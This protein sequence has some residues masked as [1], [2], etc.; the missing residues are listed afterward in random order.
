[1]SSV[2]Q[3][4]GGI[5]GGVIGF[6]VGGPSGA[7]YGA[8]LGMMAGGIIDPP[9]GP[10]INGPRLDDLTVQTSTYGAFIP[11]N[12][13][14]VA[15]TG[16][17]FWLKGDK[18]TE[19]PRV[20]E[21]GGKG[22][23]TT[24]TNLWDYS[25]TFALGLCEGPIDGV[26]RI[27][28]NSQLWYDAGASGFEQIMAS[29]DVAEN[30]TLYKGTDTQEPDP[31]IQAD[32]G[33]ANVPAYR[34]LAYIVF[35]DLQLAKYNNSLAGAQIK[36]E[37]ASTDV[38]TNQLV[39]NFSI[40]DESTWF[41]SAKAAGNQY[42][43]GG[44]SNFIAHDTNKYPVWVRYADGR[45]S[46]TLLSDEGDPLLSGSTM[47][48][49]ASP[50]DG[51]QTSLDTLHYAFSRQGGGMNYVVWGSSGFLEAMDV[52]STTGI[53]AFAERSGVIY[54]MWSVGSSIRYIAKVGPYSGVG[55]LK[56]YSSRINIYPQTPA[57]SVWG[58]YA[59]T[60]QGSSTT[61]AGSLDIKIYAESS[62]ALSVIDSY[63]LSLPLSLSSN[64]YSVDYLAT[65]SYVYEDKLY[66]VVRV[67]TVLANAGIVIVDLVS[68]SLVGVY[69][70]P[71]SFP[72]I[73]TYSVPNIKVA[74]GIVHY[75]QR[76][77][78]TAYGFVG[79]SWALSR[80]SGASAPL[81]TLKDIVSSECLKSGLLTASDLNADELTDSVRGYRVSSLGALRGGIDPL[82]AAWP[83]D[84][85][86]NGYKIKFKRRGSAS[87]VTINADELDARA[88]GEKPGAQIT[89]SREMDTLLPASLRLK[90]IDAVREYDSNEQVSDRDL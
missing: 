44:F 85:V 59:V 53:T 27:W 58:D 49:Y 29:N 30:F 39:R 86:Q 20:E 18:L 79:N 13:G 50:G 65:S 46:A 81:A 57:L 56:T 48:P 3:A 73:T 28:I 52:G 4:I 64:S 75:G 36:V 15:Q 10:V 61:A 2:G 45:S 25:A 83:F 67:S 26:R 84:V 90:Y 82:R 88:A 37:I 19:T 1:M 40:P 54:L 63:T 43:D 33:V 16:N 89:N 78:S 41:L 42:D 7:L 31:L 76:N 17:I 69:D 5:V 21:S 14:T 80:I 66:I 22:G 71:Q 47:F 55:R 77:S 62:A 74:G 38:Y 23:P 34:G 12:Y 51:M 70:A 32:K 6:F 72:H 11:R 60:A 9:D 24:T 8:Q 68:K 87:V 35:H